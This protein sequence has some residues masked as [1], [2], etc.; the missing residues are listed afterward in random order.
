[1]L[2]NN[3]DVVL[4]GTGFETHPHRDM[5]IVT[6]VRR[7]AI[8]H[9]D[10]LGNEGRTAAGDVQIMSA[11]TGVVHSEYNLE[12]NTTRIFQIW[13]LPD[14]PDLP[15][16]VEQKVFSRDQSPMLPC[17]R[18]CQLLMISTCSSSPPRCWDT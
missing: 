10:S 13:I 3:D 4:P 1:M 7:G 2:V 6:Y 12:S 14:T 5:E 15:P 16:E 11:G 18:S 8:T 9:R 17:S